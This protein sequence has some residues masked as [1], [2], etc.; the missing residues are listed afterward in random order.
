MVLC[1]TKVQ[2]SNCDCVTAA[3]TSDQHS[4][5]VSPV[6]GSAAQSVG[7]G[8]PQCQQSVNCDGCAKY[9]LQH[10]LQL[11]RVSA[12]TNCVGLRL[13]QDRGSLPNCLPWGRAPTVLAPA[14]YI[15]WCPSPTCALRQYNQVVV[16]W[17]RILV[18]G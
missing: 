17:Y 14:N 10:S 6:S 16:P 1:E 11:P 12:Q 5:S 7:Q 18:H 13:P 8:S 15:G 4:P 3:P 2:I 9:S